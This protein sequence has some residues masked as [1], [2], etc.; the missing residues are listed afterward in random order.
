MYKRTGVLSQNIMIIII[1]II[2]ILNYQNSLKTKQMIKLMRLDRVRIH[3][4]KSVVND[5][6]FINFFKLKPQKKS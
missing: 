1:I 4:I 3:I 6:D 2:I 5:Y